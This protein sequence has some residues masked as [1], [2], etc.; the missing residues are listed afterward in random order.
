MNFEAKL[1]D[2]DVLR[3]VRDGSLIAP[4]SISQAYLT[5]V[6]GLSATDAI[7]VLS[8]QG[9]FRFKRLFTQNLVDLTDFNCARI[10][11]LFFLFDFSSSLQYICCV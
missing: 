10:L 9:R 5:G 11:E 4:C 1:Q 3:P 6:R 7:D 2:I 8:P